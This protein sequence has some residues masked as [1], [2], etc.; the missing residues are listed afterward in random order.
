MQHS[1]T[2]LERAENLQ[3]LLISSAT[4]GSAGGDD[5]KALR[6]HFLDDPETAP[7]LPVFVRSKRDLFQ[8]WQFIKPKYGTYAERREFIWRE[9]A[10]LL[11]FLER[12]TKKPSDEAISERLKSFDADGVHAVWV[13]ALARRDSDPEGAITAARTLLETVCKH[14]LDAAG[15]AYDR[16]TVD[17]P[18]LYRL[19]AKE[20][21]LA[22]GQ[23]T[24]NTFKK[25]LGGVTSVVNELGSLRNRLGDAHGK[26]KR[27]VRPASRHAGLA[28]NLAGSIALFLVDTWLARSQSS[29]SASTI[30]RL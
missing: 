19:T 20:L 11:E 1:S 29:A 3:D 12:R 27:P 9:F 25:I 16:D 26:G 28:V 14:I 2:D 18:D 24:E 7:L 13:K 4:G 8:F 22:P 5:Y 6:K 23:H 30:G 17:L 21:N 10:P 15:V